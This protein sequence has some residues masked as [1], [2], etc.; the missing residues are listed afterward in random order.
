MNCPKRLLSR[1]LEI[2]DLGHLKYFLGMK[3]ARSSKGISMSQRKYVLDAYLN[4]I[5]TNNLNLTSN[6]YPNLTLIAKKYKFS[7]M[8][9]NLEFIIE[10]RLH[11]QRYSYHMASSVY[12][13]CLRSIRCCSIN[14]HLTFLGST[15]MISQFHFL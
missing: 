14:V 2:K 11:Y 3:V 5:P 6:T 1:E 12:N 13:S 9:Y 7:F 15:Y 4:F 10:L 8:M